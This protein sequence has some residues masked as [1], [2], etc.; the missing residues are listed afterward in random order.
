[1]GNATPD[2]DSSA[3]GA[4]SGYRNATAYLDAILSGDLNAL[5][6]EDADANAAALRLRAG[7]PDPPPA[8][9]VPRGAARRRR[10]SEL[11]GRRPRRNPPLPLRRPGCDAC[12]LLAHED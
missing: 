5:A 4:A 12:G 11:A 3:H 8:V 6:A 9:A 2:R 10:P 1:M 7:A